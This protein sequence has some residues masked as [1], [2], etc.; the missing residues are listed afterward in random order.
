MFI[1]QKKL[2]KT[3]FLFRVVRVKNIEFDVLFSIS[4]GYGNLVNM[5]GKG[6]WFNIAALRFNVRGL[7]TFGWG[8]NIVTKRFLEESL[9]K[10]NA[11]P[12]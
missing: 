5:F 1:F 3:S 12:I 10:S 9:K 2:T 7:N 11:S 8:F 6:F 4:I